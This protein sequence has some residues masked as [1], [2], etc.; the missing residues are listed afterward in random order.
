MRR[1]CRGE[2][3]WPALVEDCR[4]P[5]ATGPRRRRDSWRQPSLCMPLLGHTFWHADPFGPATGHAEPLGA[6][7][8]GRR[9]AGSGRCRTALVAS[10][11]KRADRGWVLTKYSDEVRIRL[12]DFTDADAIRLAAEF[13][14]LPTGFEGDRDALLDLARRYG[15]QLVGVRYNLL[16]DDEE[17]AFFGSPAWAFFREWAARDP[18]TA[19]RLSDYRSHVDWFP[20]LHQELMRAPRTFS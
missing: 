12:P 3:R 14:I 16:S 7:R 5:A 10:R 19:E 17:E 18:S 4:H 9:S 13:G 20:R 15:T 2:R 11:F 6:Q 1:G 8:A